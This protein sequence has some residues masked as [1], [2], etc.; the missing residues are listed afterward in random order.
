MLRLNLGVTLYD[1]CNKVLQMRGKGIESVNPNLREQQKGEASGGFLAVAAE[2][3]KVVVGER[4]GE[5]PLG[6]L[7]AMQ[8][9]GGLAGHF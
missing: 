2:E 7:V 5:T 9:I 4:R 6:R 3:R 8:K 1:S